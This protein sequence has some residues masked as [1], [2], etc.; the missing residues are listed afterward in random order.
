MTHLDTR[1]EHD[2]L[3]DVAVPVE[4]PWG[5]QTQRALRHF[6]ISTETLPR[7]LILALARVKRACA[8]TNAAMGTVPEPIATAIMLSLIHI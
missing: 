4:A 6:D 8:R 3:G 1:I 2:A 7:E 5:A